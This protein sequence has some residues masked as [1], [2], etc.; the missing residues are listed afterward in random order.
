MLGQCILYSFLKYNTP[1]QLLKSLYND[2]LS[3]HM[4]SQAQEFFSQWTKD[5][6]KTMNNISSEYMRKSFGSNTVNRHKNLQKYTFG[7]LTNIGTSEMNHSHDSGYDTNR[8]ILTGFGQSQTVD[9]GAVNLVAPTKPK[10]P[11]FFEQA[12][13]M[14]HK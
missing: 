10:V 11:S 4:G 5:N 2:N 6:Y 13:G 9:N 7:G 1:K 12:Y 3:G 8:E 14:T